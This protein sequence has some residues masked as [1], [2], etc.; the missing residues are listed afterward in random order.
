MR[1]K[2]AEAVFA[3]WATASYQGTALDGC[4]RRSMIEKVGEVVPAQAGAST[5]ISGSNPDSFRYEAPAESALVGTVTID[6]FEDSIGSTFMGWKIDYDS[7]ELHTPGTD[8]TSCCFISRETDSSQNHYL[9][10]N[11]SHESWMK[12]RYS[13]PAVDARTYNGIQI[14]LWA[15]K[16]QSVSIELGAMPPSVGWKGAR[17]NGIRIAQEP[18]TFRFPF[19][20][21]RN[22]SSASSDDFLD[23]MANLVAIAVFFERGSG[24]VAIDDLCFY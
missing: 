13:G 10:A 4:A 7:Q 14:T 15:D 23:Y 12:F 18:T 17:I 19:A 22:P 8:S 1:N 20:K 16:E 11:Y 21:F 5:R 24:A 3:K 6:D 9:L 2:P